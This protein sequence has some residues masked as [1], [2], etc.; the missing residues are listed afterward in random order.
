MALSPDV[1]EIA[2][3]LRL[4]VGLFLRRLRQAKVGDGE[5]TMPESSA[6]ARLDRDGPATTAALAR[7]EQISPQSM[8]ATIGALEARGLLER[9]PDPL[10]G[11]RI[12]ISV[13][14]QGRRVLRDRRS[15]RTE[16][17]ANA[18]AAEFNADEL[19][20]L[21]AAAPLIERLAHRV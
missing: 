7:S 8:G 5:L 4:S 14:D 16:L 3:A 11:R 12:V 17:I 15:A 6:L 19:A 1:D 21:M 10:D 2:A 18:L 20:T 13:S 9:R